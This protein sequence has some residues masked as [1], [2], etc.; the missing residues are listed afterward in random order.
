[1]AKGKGARIVGSVVVLGLLLLVAVG[2]AIGSR[3]TEGLE[4]GRKENKHTNAVSAAA[5]ESA[6]PD[7]TPAEASDPASGN[8]C[9]AEACVYVPGSVGKAIPSPG[10]DYAVSTCGTQLMAHKKGTEKDCSLLTMS[11]AIAGVCAKFTKDGKWC[12]MGA[13][14]RDAWIPL[15]AS[16]AKPKPAPAV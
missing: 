12:Q 1:M 11:Q 14:E 5:T 6:G 2:L 8:S 7:P 10:E 16:D 13:D 4:Q 9:T 15:P 3:V